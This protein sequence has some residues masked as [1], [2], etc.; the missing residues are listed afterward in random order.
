MQARFAAAYCGV[1]Q[2][3]FLRDVKAGRYPKPVKDGG[4]S[5]WY[6]EDLDHSLDQ[7]KGEGAGDPFMEALEV[8][9]EGRSE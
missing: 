5:L 2:T 4:N 8:F 7:L 1:S 3:K 6:I 9:G